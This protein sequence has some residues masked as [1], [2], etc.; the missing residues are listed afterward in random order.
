MYQAAIFEPITVRENI[1]MYE[2]SGSYI[3]ELARQEVISR[4]GLRAYTEGW[5]VYTTVN[6]RHQ[7]SAIESVQN[8]LF[9]YDKRH[10]WRSKDNFIDIFNEI[11]ISNLKNF[12]NS[13]FIKRN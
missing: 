5:S 11:Q 10:G 13:F 1:N 4:Y 3:A 9:A 12:D 7:K 8:E 6:S 2:V